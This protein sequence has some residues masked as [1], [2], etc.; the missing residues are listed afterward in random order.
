MYKI[1]YIYKKVFDQGKR[2]S[3]FAGDIGER[4]DNEKSD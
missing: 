2:L 4:G 1:M 3:L